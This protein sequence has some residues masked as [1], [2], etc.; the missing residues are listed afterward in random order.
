MIVKNEEKNIE[1]ALSWGKGIVSEQIVVDTGSTDRTVELA[2]QLG[3]KVYQYD[4]IDDF[5]SAKNFAISKAA[6]EWI[7]FLDADEYITEEDGKKLLP[8]LNRIQNYQY[9]GVLT[10]WINLDDDGRVLSMDAQMRIFR[11]LPKLRYHGR[12]HEHLVMEGRR[13]NA[14]D[15]IRELPIFHT[16]YGAA[17][18]KEKQES[19][20]NY[21]LI[22]K[23]LADHPDDYKMWGYLGNE[24]EAFQNW[25]QAE[26]AYR[27]AIEKMPGE[28]RGVYDVTTSQVYF[29][30]MELLLARPPVKEEEVLEFYRQAREGWPEEGDYDYLL[31]SHYVSRGNYADGEGHLLLALDKLEKYGSSLKSGLLSAGISEV[32]EML[33]SCCYYNGNPQ[34]CVRISTALLKENPYRE[35]TIAVMISA[36]RDDMEKAGKGRNGALEV[37]A[38]LGKSFYSLRDLNDKIFLFKA[39]KKAGYPELVQVIRSLFTPE[40]LIDAKA[41]IGQGM[42]DNLKKEEKLAPSVNMQEGRQANTQ[43]NMQSAAKPQPGTQPEGKLRIALF[44]SGV[45]SFNFFTDQ[46][47]KEL[48]KKGHQIFIYDLLNPPEE[49]PHS[50]KNF[51]QFTE[52][53]VDAAIC[54]D[55]FGT[56]E[57]WLM[58][59]WNRHDA[60]VAD[61]LMDPPFRFHPM[62]EH[63]PNRYHMFCCDWEHVEYVKKY[64]S[65]MAPYVAFMPHVGVVPDLD[66]PI[67]PYRHRKYDI[68]FCGTYYRPQDKL[69]ETK[70]LFPGDD[71]M[72]EIYENIYKNLIADSDLTIEQALLTTLDRL[73]LEVPMDSLKVMLNRSV[74]LDWAI[75]MYQRERVVTALAEAGLELYLLGRGWENHPVSG[76][77]NVHRIDDRIPYGDTLSYMADAKINLNVMPWF[78]AGTHD[79]I[80]NTL[81]QH[82]LPLTDSSLWITETFRDGEDI[83]LFDLKHLEKLPDMARSLLADPVKAEKIIEKGYEKVRKNFTWEHC[84]QWLLEAIEGQKCCESPAAQ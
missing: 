47:A 3:A 62:L 5:S 60:Y 45:E 2:L 78:K 76:F 23:E 33:A 70:S 80:F 67:V 13:V 51:R 11:N 29:R 83:A 72:Y 31:G 4:W 50:L 59:M 66:V 36:F 26:M 84:T 1:R 22:Q 43:T 42:D 53:K 48:Q 20:R 69:L 27:K 17:G 81:L 68:L 32:Y 57:D 82:S 49:N 54:F 8:L 37:A 35:N 21:K 65:Q 74:H 15:A 16:G 40:E 6:Y 75:R 38:F 52:Q 28:A 9:D 63:H 12:I 30:L 14:W 64:F 73:F 44:Y 25:D 79:R 7:A 71:E 34:E 58:D 77:P 10:G 24:Y 41:E 39:S 19:K 61:V 18:R 56:R 46:L 55:G